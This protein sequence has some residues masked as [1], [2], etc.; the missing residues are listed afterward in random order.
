MSRSLKRRWTDVSAR[1]K[2]R[3]SSRRLC[4][5]SSAVTRRVFESFGAIG[6]ALTPGGTNGAALWRSPSGKIFCFRDLRRKRCERKRPPPI[7]SKPVAAASVGDAGAKIKL[8]TPFDV[9]SAADRALLHRVRAVGSL[10]SGHCA[11]PDNWSPHRT[12]G[13]WLAGVSYGQRAVSRLQVLCLKRRPAAERPLVAPVVRRPCYRQ[14]NSGAWRNARLHFSHRETSNGDD[15][16][17]LVGSTN[18][19]RLV[20]SNPVLPCILLL[21]GQFLYVPTTQRSQAPP[22]KA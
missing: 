16:R 15:R 12:W 2:V 4:V 11:E 6:G 21:L 5:T 7:N 22:A 20:L 1:L 9:S 19:C 8:P 18:H 10:R 3:R 13:W 17:G 14:R